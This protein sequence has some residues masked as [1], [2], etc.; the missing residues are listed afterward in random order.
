M[1]RL[2]LLLLFILIQ[3][4]SFAQ[5]GDMLSVRKKNGVTIKSFI[6]G[7]PIVF[8]TT[9]GAYVEGVIKQIKNDSV[10]MT[11]YDIR[12]YMT[13]FGGWVIDTVTTYIVGYHYNEIASVKVFREKG[14]LRHLLGNMLMLGGAG[15]AVL[16]VFNGTYFDDPITDK[17]NVR[18]LSIAAGVFGFGFL[19]NKLFPVR[20]FST[21]RN[22]IVY[23]KMQ[24]TVNKEQ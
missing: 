15:Y 8:Q 18:S 1:Y 2:L 17:K 12:K 9:Y 6:A 22:R 10:F 11:T 16:N 21:K 24:P 19:M 20:T 4:C 13:S 3:L 5:A 23:V 14:A 7:S